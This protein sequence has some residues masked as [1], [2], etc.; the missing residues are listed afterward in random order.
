MA[1]EASR[2]SAFLHVK[3]IDSRLLVTAVFGTSTPESIK[4]ACLTLV[5]SEGCTAVPGTASTFEI[6][7]ATRALAIA[8][9]S[10]SGVACM[11]VGGLTRA[12][13]HA[14]ARAE[15]DDALRD[16]NA[17]RGEVDATRLELNVATRAAVAMRKDLDAARLDVAAAATSMALAEQLAAATLRTERALAREAAAASTTAARAEAAALR[18]QLAVARA[19][20]DAARAAAAAAT[21]AAPLLAAR[22]DAYN[23]ATQIDDAE[24]ENGVGAVQGAPV[25]SAVAAAAKAISP[26]RAAATGSGGGGGEDEDVTLGQLQGARRAGGRGVDGTL[27]EGEGK[28]RRKD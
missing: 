19:E 15:L 22:S 17:A 5:R 18:E 4:S 24:V 27:D 6:P 3:R 12:A 9:C 10:L 25:P 8:D 7:H 1:S 11:L 14:S 21:A 13:L 23:F 26:P 2:P 28:R 20:A 16:R